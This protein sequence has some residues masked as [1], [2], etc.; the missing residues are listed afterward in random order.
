MPPQF[1][2]M[3]IAEVKLVF[4]RPTGMAVLAVGLVVGVVVVAAL[5]LIRTRIQV[6]TDQMQNVGQMLKY[7]AGDVA[8]WALRARN[9]FVLPLFLLLATGN[10][11]ATEREDHTLRELLVRPV[12]RWSVVAV[13]FLA[14]MALSL[15]SL[16]ASLLPAMLGGLILSGQ[17]GPLVDAL[18]GYAASLLSDAG[19]IA[20][21]LLAGTL[22]RGAGG[23]VVSVIGL[24]LVDIGG[25][26]FLWAL[27]HF[28]LPEADSV[29]KVMPGEALAAWNGWSEGFQWQ[30]FAGL[31][32]M[33]VVAL[34]L[35]LWRVQ[36]M[37][38]P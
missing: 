9:F 32:L 26:G 11:L 17:A 13:K 25:R 12:P 19:L 23:V 30:P 1:L 7:G 2:R 33:I 35:T 10:A 28:G 16:V 20:L 24:L 8:G 4:R 6:S 38:V 36:K 37:D 14:L 3:L 31:V 34:G 22:V 18:L 27:S 29:R 21:G 15:A 5:Q